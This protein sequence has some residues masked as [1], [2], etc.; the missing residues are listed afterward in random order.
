MD[1]QTRCSHYHS[2]LD[3]VAIKF[4]CCG[5]YYP[6]HAC[7]EETAGHAAEIWPEADW[8]EK[9]VLCGVCGAEMTINEY[10][11]GGDRCAACRAAFNPGCRSH[12]RLYFAV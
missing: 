7:H 1:G 5:K 12:H 8:D 10:L 3:I 4:K 6:C 11:R 2:K 9:A